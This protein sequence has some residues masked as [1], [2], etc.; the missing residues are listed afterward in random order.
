MPK[1]IETTAG[2]AM[3]R[4]MEGA[5]IDAVSGARAFVEGQFRNPFGLHWKFVHLG[6]WTYIRVP[7][8]TRDPGS[9]AS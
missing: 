8:W 1:T 6:P 9:Q 3:I 5:E 2:A 7:V 4:T